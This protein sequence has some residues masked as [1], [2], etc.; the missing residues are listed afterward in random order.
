VSWA[1]QKGRHGLGPERRGGV[2]WA[3]QKGRHGLG[4]VRRGDMGRAQRKERGEASQRE[5]EACI[6]RQC[7][8]YGE[9]GHS[10]ADSTQMTMKS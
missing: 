7:P 8:Q 1:Q 3:Q 10:A 6:G 4:P 9:R 5:G 2:G